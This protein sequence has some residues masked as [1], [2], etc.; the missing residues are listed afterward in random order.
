[1]VTS[2]QWI[3]LVQLDDS[4]LRTPTNTGEDSHCSSSMCNGRHQ[5]TQGKKQNQ[6]IQNKARTQLQ[7]MDALEEVETFACLVS[8]T[9]KQ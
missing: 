5:H 1:M 6:E 2:S 4:I 9:Y 8:I 7:L 3:A